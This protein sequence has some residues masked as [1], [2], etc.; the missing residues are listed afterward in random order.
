MTVISSTN[1]RIWAQTEPYERHAGRNS[2]GLDRH[3][4]RNSR[5]TVV[6]RGST[7]YGAPC[8][9]EILTSNTYVLTFGNAESRLFLFAALCFNIESM[10]KVLL[11]YSY[12]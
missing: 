10:Q 2:S 12:V 1:T 9:A 4:G 3:T 6:T 7:V 5:L 8:K 11:C